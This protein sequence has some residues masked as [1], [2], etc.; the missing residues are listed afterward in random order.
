MDTT[1]LPLL[2]AYGWRGLFRRLGV[3]PTLADVATI[4]LWASQNA[5]PADERRLLRAMSQAEQQIMEN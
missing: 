3:V 5:T 4:R 2:A 1:R